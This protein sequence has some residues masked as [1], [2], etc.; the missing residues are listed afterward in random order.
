MLS[1]FLCLAL[2]PLFPLAANDNLFVSRVAVGADRKG[3]GDRKALLVGA[4]V[5]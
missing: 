5:S 2:L 4:V 1:L 3:K